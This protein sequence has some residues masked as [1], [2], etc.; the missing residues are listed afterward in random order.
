MRDPLGRSSKVE[1][2]ELMEADRLTQPVER[3]LPG[4]IAAPRQGSPRGGTF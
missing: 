1:H 4:A 3:R 2:G